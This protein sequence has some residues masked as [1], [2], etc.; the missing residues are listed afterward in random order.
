MGRW[1]SKLRCRTSDGPCLWSNMAKPTRFQHFEG[2]KKRSSCSQCII[3]RPR[4][5]ERVLFQSISASLGR[6]WR[7]WTVHENQS[8]PPH[9]SVAR[10]LQKGPKLGPGPIHVTKIDFLGAVSCHDQFLPSSVRTLFIPG[11]LRGGIGCDKGIGYNWVISPWMGTS[12]VNELEFSDP[13]SPGLSV[14]N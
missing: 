6:K 1:R 7:T 5:A 14:Y 10:H 11:R 9:K 2:T 13:F 4:S 12:I 3:L 8:I